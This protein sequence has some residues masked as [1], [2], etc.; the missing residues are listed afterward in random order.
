MVA[1][2]WNEHIAVQ[3]LFQAADQQGSHYSRLLCF[4][5]FPFSLSNIPSDILHCLLSHNILQV[6]WAS[7]SWLTVCLPFICHVEYKRLLVMFSIAFE[8]QGGGNISNLKQ[9]IWSLKIQR[10]L[11]Q[12]FCNADCFILLDDFLY[13]IL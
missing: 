13:K 3:G 10:A 9:N 2:P 4:Y 1:L 12:R 7:F 6:P 11:I 5:C 8:I